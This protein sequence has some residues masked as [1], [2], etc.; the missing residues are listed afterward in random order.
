MCACVWHSLEKAMQQLS[1][2]SQPPHVAARLCLF[3]S[4]CRCCCHINLVNVQFFTFDTHAGKHTL[5]DTHT[6]TH[7][8]TSRIPI[9]H[10]LSRLIPCLELQRRQTSHTLFTYLP[11]SL[12]LY[13]SPS[14]SFPPD[15]L[16][17]FVSHPAQSFSCNSSRASIFLYFHLTQRTYPD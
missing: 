14:F 3:V 8:R 11:L 4:C 5:T 12:S 15:W 13:L 1:G 10:S 9:G 7:T 17:I 2:K 6:R 16:L